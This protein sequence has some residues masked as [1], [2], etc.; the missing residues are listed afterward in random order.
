MDRGRYKYQTQSY[1]GLKLMCIVYLTIPLEESECISKHGTLK[2]SCLAVCMQKV[3]RFK[4]RFYIVQLIYPYLQEHSTFKSRLTSLLLSCPRWRCGGLS[5]T[6]RNLSCQG[7]P[8]SK[9][10]T[11]RQN[12]A[13]SGYWSRLVHLE[14]RA[15]W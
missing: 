8:R 11:R 2:P 14:A 10:F 13:G 7:M 4:V 1:C 3:E 12:Q 6:P 9:I 15:I 5:N